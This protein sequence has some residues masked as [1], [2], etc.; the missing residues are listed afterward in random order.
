M[1]LGYF[2]WIPHHLQTGS[3]DGISKGSGVVNASCCH[4]PQRLASLIVSPTCT[5]KSLSKNPVSRKHLVLAEAGM[6]SHERFFS[7]VESNR[8]PFPRPSASLNTL[9]FFKGLKKIVCE[10][11][12]CISCK[13]DLPGKGFLSIPLF[14]TTAHLGGQFGSRERVTIW[15]M[16]L[17][18]VL[19]RG[20]A[21]RPDYQLW[22]RPCHPPLPCPESSCPAKLSTFEG[23]LLLLGKIPF[24]SQISLLW[25][26]ALGYDL[27]SSGRKD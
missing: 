14:L 2:T 1:V 12:G 16:G 7:I 18:W 19:S 8:K 21:M 23:E 11:Q 26:A 17:L 5:C 24:H 6:L 25:I 27:T 10:G 20:S 15:D 9:T 4:H 13:Q 22:F 3:Y